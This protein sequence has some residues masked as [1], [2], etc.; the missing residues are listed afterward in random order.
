MGGERTLNTDFDDK[1]LFITTLSDAEI[2]TLGL[3]DFFCI[4]SAFARKKNP[5]LIS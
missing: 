1:F 5:R 3:V 4:S 2:Q